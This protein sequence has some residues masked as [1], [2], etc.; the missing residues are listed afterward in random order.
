MR[1]S[2]G[3]LSHPAMGHTSKKALLLSSSFDFST[4][5]GNNGGDGARGRGRGSDLPKF[6]FIDS[7]P[8]KS[9]STGSDDVSSS[10]IP[11][12]HGRGK[13]FSPP[14]NIPQFSS[15]V[16]PGGNRGSVT[17]RGRGTVLPSSQSEKNKL[18]TPIFLRKDGEPLL[19]PKT[20]IEDRNGTHEKS[21]LP[22]SLLSVISGSGRGKP[23]QA[24]TNVV[25]EK[26]EES[27]RHVRPRQQPVGVGPR[28]PRVA[29][30]RMSQADAVNKARGILSRGG[31][32][33]GQ[34]GVGGPQRGSRGM[35]T[36]GGG[37]GR[38]QR[39]GF[40]GRGRGR[41]RGRLYR[42]DD[43]EEEDEEETE[44]D[45]ANEDKISKYLGPEKLAV[46]VEAF[47]EASGS[48]LPSPEEDAYVDAMHTNLLLECEPEYLMAEFDS[49]PDID[50]KPPIALR[51]AL[52]KMK[53]FL[54][55]YENIQSEKEWQDVVEATMKNVP[56]MKELVDYYSG[57]NRVT[58][59]K[60]VGE[61]E[62]V[63]KTLPATAPLS[64]KRFTDRAVLSLQSNPGWGFDK[65]CQ[66]MDKLVSQSY[67]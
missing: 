27:N 2:V 67:E 19:P 57:P 26:V 3:K 14:P 36:R 11:L 29:S 22:S 54:I 23:V 12:G 42:D 35:E 10:Q 20:P 31:D 48:V 60:Q 51:D 33:G 55:A 1:R 28:E 18:K 47:E 6:N 9:E 37:G 45:K 7:S 16:G 50:E 64:V 63:A 44:L 13:P 21:F 39:G 41:G 38:G 53:P 58:A 66:F 24:A 32:G 61:L 30:P 5:S 52:E 49:N 62:R 40:R 25:N 59:K 4:S 46:L 56:L 8:E 34:D 15:F 65:K 43:N 17:G